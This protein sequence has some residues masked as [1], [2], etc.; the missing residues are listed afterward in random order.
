MGGDV[1][2][3]MMKHLKC[4]LKDESYRKFNDNGKLTEH[5]QIICALMLI[6]T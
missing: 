5:E 1:E 6:H 2:V 4:R 3:Y